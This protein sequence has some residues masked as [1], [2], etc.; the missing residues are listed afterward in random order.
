MLSRTASAAAVISAVALVLAAVSGYFVS[1][2]EKRSEDLNSEVAALRD[3]LNQLSGRLLGIEAEVQNLSRGTLQLSSQISQLANTNVRLLGELAALNQSVSTQTVVEII[4]ALNQSLTSKLVT[5]NQSLASLKERVAEAELN[6]SQLNS[7]ITAVNKEL[8]TISR[9]TPG[10]VYEKVYKSVVVIRTSVGQ[11]SGFIYGE[12]LV[13]TN[14]HVVEGVNEADIQFYDQTRTT[15]TVLATDPYSDVAVL[16]IDRKPADAPPL[17]LGNSSKIWI[18][19]TV[20][21]IGNPL[22][23]TGSLSVGVISQVNRLLDLYP[24]IVPVLQLDITIAPGSSGGPLLNLDGEVV[25]VTNAGTSVGFSFAIPSNMV[26]RVASDLI[27]KGYYQHPYFGFSALTLTPENIRAYNIL[28]I[29][30]FQNGLMVTKVMP[31][32]PAEKAGLRAATQVRTTTGLAYKP[33]DIILAVDGR[34]TYTF[35]EWSAYVSL[36]VS[37]NQKVALTIL[38]EGKTINLEITPTARPPYQG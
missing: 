17:T 1:L 6:V 34:R 28:D 12:N 16:K 29:D 22:G 11:G 8:A 9:Q 10:R 35:E 2:Q 20:V 38:R 21:A 14:W 18:G 26:R 3:S 19:E 30:P 32:T 23:L 25:G 36:N 4:S 31:N 7:T 5:L 37:P 24:I 27:S 33:G 15:A 13:L